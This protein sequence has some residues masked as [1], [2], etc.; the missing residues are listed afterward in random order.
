MGRGMGVGTAGAETKNSDTSRH[1]QQYQGQSHPSQGQHRRTQSAPLLSLSPLAPTA[2]TPIET[3]GNNPLTPPVTSSGFGGARVSYPQ[4]QQQDL[5]SLQPSNYPQLNPMAQAV[6][7]AS[8][9]PFP[10]MPGFQGGIQAVPPL[11]WPPFFAQQTAPGGFYSQRPPAGPPGG[12]MAS[13]ANNMYSPQP[14]M[15]TTQWKIN[16]NSQPQMPLSH[17]I[18]QAQGLLVGGPSAHNRKIGLYKTEICRNWEEKQSCRYGVKCQFAHG[19]T[20][21]RNVPR[22]PKYKTEICRTF[23]VTG[24]CPYGKRCCFIHP[25]ATS[26]QSGPLSP[27][28]PPLSGGSNGNMSPSGV[29]DQDR[30]TQHAISLL[31]RLDIKRGSPEQL[32][33]NGSNARQ[34]P[35][36]NVSDPSGFVYPGLHLNGHSNG[37]DGERSSSVPRI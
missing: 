31:A 10:T 2:S 8:F 32:N 25:T 17:L 9:T 21:V 14:V 28:G 4:P 29:D 13:A 35:D 12:P 15:P 16:P 24:S 37:V 11:M 23:W 34:T 3:P 36:S 5:Q 18:N 26:H 1:Q 27:Q 33:G 20:D 19:S 7:A 6:A 22:H 30:E